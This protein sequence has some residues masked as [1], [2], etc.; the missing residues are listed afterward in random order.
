MN[1]KVLAL[2]LAIAL[3]ILLVGCGADS[4]SKASQKA[5]SCGSAV[6]QICEDYSNHTITAKEAC[7]KVNEILDE[8]KYVSELTS[9]DDNKVP[10]L[11]VQVA[12][13]SIAID[14][15]TEVHTPTDKS[16]DKL[17]EDVETLKN[18]IDD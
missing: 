14:L 3:T 17:L 15:I 13:S 9:D 10:D 11:S 4:K 18:K 5:I 1:R 16:Y 7:D 2:C 8:M 6:L 12:I